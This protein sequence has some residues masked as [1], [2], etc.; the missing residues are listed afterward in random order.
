MR[1]GDQASTDPRSVDEPTDPDEALEPEISS[2]FERSRWQLVAAA[3][4]TSPIIVAVTWPLA[5]HSR[6]L[7]FLAVHQIAI[8]AM[9]LTFALPNNEADR[10]RRLPPMATVGLVIGQLLLSSALFFDPVAARNADFAFGVGLVL[11]A[12]AAGT[13]AVLGPMKLLARIA[14]ICM[15]A[16]YT[17]AGLVYGHPGIAI[18]TAFFLVMIAGVAVEKTSSL[19]DEL[20]SLRDEASLRAETAEAIATTDALTGLTNRY[21]L[22]LN[23]G[24]LLQKEVSGIFIDLDKF[25]EVNDTLGHKAGD[26]VLIEVARRLR[27]YVRPSDTVARLGGDEFFILLWSDHEIPVM[28]I[29]NRIREAVER[30]IA[31]EGGVA[32]VSASIGLSRQSPGVLNLEALIQ[33]ADEALYMAKSLGKNQVFASSVRLN[34]NSS[35]T[36]GSSDTERSNGQFD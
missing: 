2:Y 18:G 22:T 23:D 7:W 24:E 32:A 19:F 31:V 33:N 14:L 12:F 10:E 35:A 30:P 9:A 16:P 27:R 17:V 28:D 20:E 21:G 25:K 8:I 6:M 11:F 3:V 15:L 5:D 4:I 1:A 29:A 34:L 13:V 26:E 36:G